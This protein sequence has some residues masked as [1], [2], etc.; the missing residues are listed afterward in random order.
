[1]TEHVALW[2]QREADEARAEQ[3]KA[4][5]ARQLSE[6]AWTPYKELRAVTAAIEAAARAKAAADSALAASCNLKAKLSEFEVQ[7]ASVP[8]AAAAAAAQLKPQKKPA[9]INLAGGHGGWLGG[10]GGHRLEGDASACLII[11]PQS[12]QPS[13]SP[14]PAAAAAAAQAPAI[15]PVSHQE[16]EAAA[17]AAAQRAQL[18]AIAAAHAAAAAGKLAARAARVAAL[19]ARRAQAAKAAGGTEPPSW[20][21]ELFVA[22]GKMRW[23]NFAAQCF[24]AAATL[25]FCIYMLVQKGQPGVYLTIVTGIMGCF[26]PNSRFSSGGQQQQQQQQQASE[27]QQQGEGREGTSAVTEARGEATGSQVAAVAT[28]DG[29]ADLTMTWWR[30]VLQNIIATSVMVFCMFKLAE[31][32]HKR[33]AAADEGSN[34]VGNVQIS[35][36]ELAKAQGIYLPIITAIYGYFMPTPGAA[37]K[38]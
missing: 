32:I 15:G 23:W 35:E 18:L 24:I 31:A 30:F 38:R 6:H 16:A 9:A 19:A 12:Q 3:T 25:C 22:A 1:M 2:T 37:K 7:A 14:P 17:M 36:N 13:M 33:N 11:T 5:A 28:Q 20:L 10:T 4:A 21:L 26:M 8:T 34:G 27:Q 29:E